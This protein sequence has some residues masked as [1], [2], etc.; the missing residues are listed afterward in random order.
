MVKQT[1]SLRESRK[2]NIGKGSYVE[3]LSNAKVTQESPANMFVGDAMITAKRRILERCLVVEEEGHVSIDLRKF[4]EWGRRI[5]RASQGLKKTYMGGNEVQVGFE[6]H[7][8]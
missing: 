7:N 5:R 1:P 6:W 4:D 8:R 2:V 3:V